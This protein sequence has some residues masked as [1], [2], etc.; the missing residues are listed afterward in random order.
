MDLMRSERSMESTVAIVYLCYLAILNALD[1][2]KRAL[3]DV[4]LRFWLAISGLV[5]R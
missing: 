5:V 1:W 4:E 2:L 3:C